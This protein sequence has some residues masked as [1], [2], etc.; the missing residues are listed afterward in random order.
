MAPYWTQA[1]LALVVLQGLLP[2][3]ALYAIKKV[4]DTVTVG[5]QGQDPDVMRHL[6]FWIAFA[7]GV[8]LLVALCRSLSEIVSEAQAFI[9]REAM[10]DLVHKQSV[11]LDLAHYE[12]AS[13]RDM[14]YRA[15]QEAPFRP[16]AILTSLTQIAQSAVSLM[17]ITAL[18]LTLSIP[19]T[20]LLVCCTLPGGLLRFAFSR[21]MRDLQRRQTANERL[22]YFYHYFLTAEYSAK[23]LKLFNLGSLFRKR[24]NDL[25]ALLRG[26]QMRT[27]R[28]RS[29]ADFIGQGIATIVLFV[30]LGNIALSALRGAITLGA[31]VMYYQAFQTGLSQ[32]QI[33][34]RSVA[35]LFEHCLFLENF[36][37]F[38]DLKPAIVA[39]TPVQIA[40]IKPVRGIR[41]HDVHFRYPGRD[42]DALQGIDLEIVPGQVIALVGANGSGKSTIA[43]L[44]PRLY[45]PSSGKITIDGIDLRD[46]DPDDWR[47]RIS[48]VFQDFFQ[49]P[50]SALDNIRFGD[51]NR[52][53]EPQAIARAAHA[54]GADNLIEGLPNKYDTI[55]GNAYSNGHELSGGEWQKV[56]VARAYFR[57]SD[58]VILDEPSSA[59]DPLAEMELF[60]RFRELI[61]GKSAMLISHRFSTVQMADY[62]YVLDH[63]QIL[64]RGTHRDLLKLDGIYARFYNAQASKFQNAAA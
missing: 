48:A 36:Y 52:P 25:R 12:T 27:I 50:L 19:L 3:A 39:K 51:V 2:L 53:P 49:Y 14:M 54:A 5:A 30:C 9:V 47:R 18:F 10:T 59:L 7:G 62:I 29:F 57:D 6:I 21:R 35:Q 26:E 32:L 42:C 31:M 43:K 38:L 55:L 56:A 37:Q 13:Y 34:M 24:Y 33:L 45:D 4:V 17:G 41:F 23:E 44:I 63:G 20:L 22:S 15:Q 64:E 58:M 1:T 8:A 28:K 40:P 16:L 61:D 60:Q 46:L 11:S